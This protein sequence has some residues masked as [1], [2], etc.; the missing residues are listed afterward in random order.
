ML[1]LLLY[2]LCHSCNWAKQCKYCSCKHLWLKVI[3]VDWWSLVEQ[4]L[5]KTQKDT[6]SRRERKKSQ[7]LYFRL[8]P[9]LLFFKQSKE[10]D[11]K[12]W[13]HKDHQASSS[14]VT[15]LDYSSKFCTLS[16]LLQLTYNNISTIWLAHHKMLIQYEK[17]FGKVRK[18][19][20]MTCGCEDMSSVKKELIKKFLFI[21]WPSF[22]KQSDAGFGW[23]GAMPTHLLFN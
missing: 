5:G 15:T 14:N 9:T 20:N 21:N 3:N 19:S 23:F 4:W 12:W 22:L 16:I 1:S 8:S 7:R 13:R 2:L 18:F 6:Q 10:V 11:L 17:V